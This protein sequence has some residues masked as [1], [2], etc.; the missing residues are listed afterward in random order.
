[1]THADHDKLLVRIKALFAKTTEAG[2]TEAEQLAAVEKAHELIAKYQIDLG[3]EELKREG[4]VKKQID[5]MD[6]AQF[7]F[8][9]RIGFALEK[10]CEVSTWYMP[11]VRRLFILGLRS[12]A[13]F[14]EYL[15]KSL[16][17]FAVAG[18]DLHVA[19]ERKMRI[20]LGTPMSATE[21]RECRRSHL[22]GCANRISLRLK[23]LAAQ[24]SM[25]NAKP[26]SYGTLVKLDKPALIKAEMERLDIRLSW[27]SA[28][29]GG[30]DR[31]SFA[32][33]SAHGSRASFGRP[34][35]GGGRIA[36]LIGKS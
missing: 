7:I 12:D 3:A 31:D 25:Q 35:G 6:P 5:G 27:G 24:R 9:R 11:A 2:A 30:S 22:V 18:A 28:L 17:A 15:I 29:S 1:M 14:A 8:A 20:A 23:G 21:T 36:G 26:G 13:E 16:A 10:F 34:V 19:T 32:A 4:F 33:G